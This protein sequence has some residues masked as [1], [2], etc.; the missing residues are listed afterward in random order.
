MKL[1]ESWTRPNCKLVSDINVTYDK[2]VELSYLIPLW[3]LSSFLRNIWRNIQQIHV[4]HAGFYSGSSLRAFTMILFLCGTLTYLNCLHNAPLRW[5]SLFWEFVRGWLVGCW[6]HFGIT[7]RLHLQR[8]GKSKISRNFQRKGRRCDISKLYLTN[9]NSP[10]HLL[11]K[12]CI[13]IGNWIV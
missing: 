10:K 2:V 13:A 11:R 12:V 6:W 7:Y 8:S 1:L 5:S 9:L 3:Q 4:T